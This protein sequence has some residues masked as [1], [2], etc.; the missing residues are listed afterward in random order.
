[1][2][3]LEDGYGIRTVQGLLGHRDVSNTMMYS[4]VLSREDLA[5]A[6]RPIVYEGC[7]PTAS[8]SIVPPRALDRL[9]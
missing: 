1:M 2:H 6:V 9:G 3:L 4:N 5:S 8:A 7:S